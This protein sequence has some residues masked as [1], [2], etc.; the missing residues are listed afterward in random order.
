MPEMINTQLVG[1]M[2]I[3]LTFPKG[4][5]RNQLSGI[6]MV[7]M[8]EIINIES[9]HTMR[10]HFNLLHQ[11]EIASEE[12]PVRIKIMVNIPK[13]INT[14]PIHTIG[15]YF[16]LF[17]RQIASEERNQLE[18]LMVIIPKIINIQPIIDT[19]NVYFNQRGTMK[20]IL[21]G[22]NGG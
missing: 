7:I 16:N 19:R 12:E 4:E 3:Y 10:I 5:K 13:M 18:Q 20:I 6:I 21:H 22:T 15:I 1:N 11:K 9:L 2:V 17:Q 8:P 14:E